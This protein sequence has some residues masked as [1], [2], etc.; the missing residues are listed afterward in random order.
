MLNQFFTIA[1]LAAD[2]YRTLLAEAGADRL[3][4]QAAEATTARPERRSPRLLRLLRP[5]RAL[6]RDHQ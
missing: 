3:A 1:D 4:R 5:A 2:R 6:P